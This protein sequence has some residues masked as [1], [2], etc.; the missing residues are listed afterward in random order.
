M[1]NSFGRKNF[2][3]NIWTDFG[4]GDKLTQEKKHFLNKGGGRQDS[5]GRTGSGFD[6][7]CPL[8]TLQTSRSITPN[9]RGHIE[10]MPSQVGPAEVCPPLLMNLFK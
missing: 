10:P 9:N 4:R 6:P 2:N 3:E 7:P 8:S 5:A 1:G